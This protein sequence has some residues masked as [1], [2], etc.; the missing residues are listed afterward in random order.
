MKRQYG[1]L[2]DRIET[3]IRLPPAEGAP[4]A[5]VMDLLE[6]IRVLFNGQFLSLASQVQLFQYVIGEL[7]QRKLRARPPAA[8]AQVRQDKF[9]EPLEV[10]FRRNALPALTFRRLRPREKET[11]GLLRWQD[12]NGSVPGSCGQIR[13]FWKPATSRS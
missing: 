11:V 5:G 6:S 12:A 8:H 4:D 2:K 1:S 9:P 10:Q 7:A 3:A 13:P